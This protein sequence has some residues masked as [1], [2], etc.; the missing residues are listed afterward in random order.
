VNI[1]EHFKRSGVTASA[2]ANFFIWLC[3]Q[4]GGYLS[5]L[6][7]QKLL[8]YAQG[9]HLALFQGRRLF[10]AKFQAWIHGPVLPQIW[11]KYKDFGYKPI[12]QNVE[13]PDFPED[14]EKF[15]REIAKVFF[16]LDAY[17]LEL[18]THRE[19]PW[20]KARKGL[21]PDAKSTNPISEVDMLT[22]LAQVANS[23]GQGKRAK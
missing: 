15:L 1:S 13:K 17:Q 14:T 9:W 23:N 22:H 2:V 12:I 11:H 5:N 4:S 19:L 6:K 8:Y 16:P 7:L 10:N 20:Q 3:N 18:A 21:P